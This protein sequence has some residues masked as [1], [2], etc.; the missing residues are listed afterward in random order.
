[1]I[2][3]LYSIYFIIA[4]SFFGTHCAMAQKIMKKE[5]TSTGITL[6]SIP[7]DAI[8]KITILPSLESK[9]EVDV[10][11]YGDFA[12]AVV[13]EEHLLEG[14][15]SL[16]TGFAPF[17]KTIDDKLAAHKV[18]AIE[19]TLK[20]PQDL[21]LEVQ[22]K[23]ASVYVEGSYKNLAVSLADGGCYLRN[24]SGNAH[25]KTTTGTISVS[26]KD[27]VWGKAVSEYG[28]VENTLVKTKKFLVEAESIKGDISLLQTK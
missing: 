6:V 19:L 12:E 24:F 11:I 10:Y 28:V 21:S 25:L 18:I 14:T 5:Y 2:N 20:V 27:D 3:R 23:L 26:A 7:D 16:H 13:L 22:S 8:Y 17:F 9:I 1:M 4:L 15:L